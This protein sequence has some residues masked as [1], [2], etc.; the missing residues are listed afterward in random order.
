MRILYYVFLVL[1]ILFV[2]FGLVVCIGFIPEFGGI[3]LGHFFL[4][5]PAAV[6]LSACYLGRRF[7]KVAIYLVAIPL[8]VFALCFWMMSMLFIGLSYDLKG[9]T[10]PKKYEKVLEE[11]WSPGDNLVDHFPRPIPPEARNTKFSYLPGFLQGGTHIQLRIELPKSRIREIYQE[12]SEN[13]KQ[14]HIGGDAFSLVNSGTDGLAST[15]FY[16]SESHEFPDDY[17]IFIYDAKPYK[18]EGEHIWNHGYSKGVAVSK[19]RNEVI[20]WAES[21]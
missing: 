16:T 6:L 17:R 5:L 8:F 2:I 20:Y 15:H 7:Q 21:W 13:A 1:G 12:A 9:V 11:K 14:S 4:F 19:E 3:S 18:Q 10:D